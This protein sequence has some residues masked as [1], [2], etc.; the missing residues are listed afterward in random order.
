MTTPVL[1]LGRI[2]VLHDDVP[3]ISFGK[4]RSFVMVTVP[5]LILEKGEVL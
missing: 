2:E 3:L 1:V 5:R 4:G